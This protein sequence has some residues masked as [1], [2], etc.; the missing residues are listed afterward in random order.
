M[1]KPINHTALLLPSLLAMDVYDRDQDGGL[2][3]VVDQK[4]L[5]DGVSSL[6]KKEVPAI[7]FFAKA[8]KAKDG[9]LYISY[10]GTDD[11]SLDINSTGLAGGAFID[12]KYG[13]PL[14]PGILRTVYGG[15]GRYGEVSSRGQ[16]CR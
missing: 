10:R 15:S 12:L 11:G 16:G 4:A 5:P 1:A 6:D 2:H 8:Y 7:G 14:T 13:Y 3:K 9:A